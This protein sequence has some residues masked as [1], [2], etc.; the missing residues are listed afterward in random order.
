[1]FLDRVFGNRIPNIT[2]NSDVD[3]IHARIIT[4]QARIVNAPYAHLL[5]KQ[6]A[7]ILRNAMRQGCINGA[8]DMTARLRKITEQ[9]LASY[10]T[11]REKLIAKLATPNGPQNCLW[12]IADLDMHIA[13]Y[14]RALN[15]DR[16]ENA[17]W[18]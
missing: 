10:R 14:Q 7:C 9:N 15:A 12:R 17:N 5:C 11:E 13:M 18:K 6:H 1:M 8:Y 2:R 16:F 3:V 4:R